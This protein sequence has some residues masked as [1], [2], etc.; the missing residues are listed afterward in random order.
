MFKFRSLPLFIRVP[1]HLLSAS[2]IL[3]APVS[4]AL[5]HI[6][7]PTSWQFILSVLFAPLSFFI[8][9]FCFLNP[10]L[11]EYFNS[12]EID[13]IRRKM[14]AHIMES[15]VENRQIISISNEI[16]QKD[17]LVFRQAF[18]PFRKFLSRE[19]Q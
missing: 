8:L 7:K 9:I 3:A 17:D 12:E 11:I 19:E 13:S 2:G 15:K 6:I 4:T 16:S 18:K 10:L 5:W 14:A 1:V